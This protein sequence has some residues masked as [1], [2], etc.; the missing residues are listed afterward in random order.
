MGPWVF[1]R[2][3][4]RKLAELATI[5]C[6]VV[7]AKLTN[8]SL[9]PDQR[10]NSSKINPIPFSTFLYPFHLDLPGP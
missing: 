9:R 2:P 4:L 10:S 3:Q 7:T 6:F 1:F 8:F 5:V